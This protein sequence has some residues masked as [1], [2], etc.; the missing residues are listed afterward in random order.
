MLRRRFNQPTGNDMRKFT[1]TFAILCLLLSACA[2]PLPADKTAYAGEWDAPT[3]SLLI[4]SSGM[5]SYKR[6]EG[7]TSTSINAPVKNFE[8]D[9][10]VVGVGPATTTFKVSAPP[11]QVQG[12]WKMTV[13]GVELTRKR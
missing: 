8:G 2:K 11:H 5:V 7:H 4:T 9:D 1:I 3:M 6:A 10:F 13:D 12:Q